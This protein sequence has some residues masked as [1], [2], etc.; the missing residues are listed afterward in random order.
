MKKIY[1]VFNQYGIG[2]SGQEAF[3]RKADAKRYFKKIQSYNMCINTHMIEVEINSEHGNK[4]I[5]STNTEYVFG[6]SMFAELDLKCAS[7]TVEDP[8]PVKEVERYGNTCYSVIMAKS[9][10]ECEDA[11]KMVIEYMSRSDLI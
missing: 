5:H 1:V 4:I 3:T 2:I 9:P 8:G 6:S 7:V 11:R 10:T